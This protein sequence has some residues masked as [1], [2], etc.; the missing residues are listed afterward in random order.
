[1]AGLDPVVEESGETRRR[2]NRA[3]T[4]SPHLRWALVE[5][6]V[7]AHR[8]TA[9]DVALDRAARERPTTTVARLTVAPKTGKRVFHTLPQL[10]LKAA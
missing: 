4:G 6:A 5:A 9:P 7:H 1:M 2:G 3:K 10:E 8:P